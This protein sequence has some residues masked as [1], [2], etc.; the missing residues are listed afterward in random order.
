[1]ADDRGYNPQLRKSR[2][3]DEDSTVEVTPDPPTNTKPIPEAVSPETPVERETLPEENKRVEKT[4]APTSPTESISENTIQDISS[5]SEEPESKSDND[6]PPLIPSDPSETDLKPDERDP[7]PTRDGSPP[8]PSLVDETHSPTEPPTEEE[9]TPETTSSEPLPHTGKDSPEPT[10]P[11]RSAPAPV[12]RTRV[13]EEEKEYKP[14]RYVA[15]ENAN[16]YAK[17]KGDAK[18]KLIICYECNEPHHIIKS[19]T[20]SLCPHCGSYISIK[21]HKINSFWNTSIKTRGN[22]IV[23]KKGLLRNLSVACNNLIIE[24]T[25]HSS[26]DCQN[27]LIIRASGKITGHIKC[28]RVIIEKK[29]EVEFDHPL[30]AE[31][32]VIDGVLTCPKLVCTTQATIHKKSKLIGGLEAKSLEL[33]EGATIEGAIQLG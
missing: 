16:K 7:D 25:F 13:I 19:A 22:V 10:S 29:T 28:R 30:V 11:K 1:M 4:P 12:E 32:A 26:A 14:S 3:E 8:S 18:D 24:G 20:S 23:E 2:E 17:Y 21:D 9:K 33:Q 5:K 15:K 31:E 6:F 27:D